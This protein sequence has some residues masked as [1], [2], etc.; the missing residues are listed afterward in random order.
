MKSINRVTLLGHLGADPDVKV[1][2]NQNQLASLNVATNQK[3]KD[4]D[5]NWQEKTEWHRVVCWDKLAENAG[6]NLKKGDAVFL[7][8][9]ISTRS[10]EDN[11]GQKKYVTE[12]VAK[13]IVPV[14]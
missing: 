14:N 6:K 9:N 2:A 13:D 12:I 3:W 11:D 8:G 7:E 10:W 5:G 4:S 1:T